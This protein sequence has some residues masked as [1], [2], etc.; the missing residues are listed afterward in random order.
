MVH[1]LLPLAHENHMAEVVDSV[2][3]QKS[4]VLAAHLHCLHVV[5]YWYVVVVVL[6]HWLFAEM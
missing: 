2:E 4:D 6:V 5:A 1:R 3:N